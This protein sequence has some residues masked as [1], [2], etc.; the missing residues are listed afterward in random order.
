MENTPEMITE[1][2][3][4]LKKLLQEIDQALLLSQQELL[5]SSELYELENGVYALLG[6][7]G[8]AFG[9]I[10]KRKIEKATPQ[11]KVAPRAGSYATQGGALEKLSPLRALIE[12]LLEA[13]T[14]I[15]P[16]NIPSI[17]TSQNPSMREAI[18]DAQ[19]LV[20]KNGAPNAVDRF[21]TLLQSYLQ[22]QCSKANI[23]FDPEASINIL[24]KLMKENH[25]VLLELQAKEP[26]AV[27]ILKGMSNTLDKLSTLRNNKSLAHSKG[28][29]P[30]DEAG[31]VIDS[32]NTILRYLSSK[33]GS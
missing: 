19:L 1:K 22:E 5:K 24:L 20:D 15:K 29:L 32:V 28:L 9:D 31:F 8:D 3:E 13:E 14:G 4:L 26:E 30:S 33:L 23:S 2:E 17:D 7:I 6:E 27:E 11:W 21:H 25:P 16:I 10:L 12:E 18:K